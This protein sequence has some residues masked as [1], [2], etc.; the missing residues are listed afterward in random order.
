MFGHLAA[1]LDPLSDPP[2][3]PA[4]LAPSAFGWSDAELDQPVDAHPFR[5]DGGG[6]VRTLFAALRETYCGSL[7]VE[8]AEIL[9]DPRRGWLEERMER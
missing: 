6:T 3:L 8:F 4:S 5:G 1:H 7:G 2:A 9:D